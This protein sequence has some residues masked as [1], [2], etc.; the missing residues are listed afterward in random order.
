MKSFA[1]IRHT[2]KAKNLAYKP[3]FRENYIANIGNIFIN[4]LKNEV[5]DE[6]TKQF[7]AEV[8]S[9]LHQE[10]REHFSSLKIALKT[11]SPNEGE[12]KYYTNLGE[13]YISPNDGY[14]KFYTQNKEFLTSAKK[15]KNLA[16]AE[17]YKAKETAEKVKKIN[18]LKLKQNHSL[19]FEKYYN[20]DCVKHDFDRSCSSDE[21]LI[22]ITD[23]NPNENLI[24]IKI[25]SW[26]QSNKHNK[27]TT[28]FT[29]WI[30]LKEFNEKD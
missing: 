24:Q 16:E 5:A 19:D 10:I 14:V 30:K 27:K 11:C 6:A 8:P 15:A 21:I 26:Y 1:N 23:F 20:T 25:F 12:H 2:P 9:E 7:W 28:L 18:L 4:I 13:V 22:R 3:P 29:G 17:T